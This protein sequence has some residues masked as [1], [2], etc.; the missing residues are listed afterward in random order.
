MWRDA[1]NSECGR[2]RL[3]IAQELIDVIGP[4]MEPSRTRFVT[5]SRIQLSI[6]QQLLYADGERLRARL[7]D[8]QAAAAAGDF[9]ECAVSTANARLAM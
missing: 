9:A 6:L 2:G 7:I 5:Q 3:Q 1:G 8:N 4:G